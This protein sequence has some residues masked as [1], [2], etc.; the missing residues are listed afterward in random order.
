M[1]ILVAQREKKYG[2]FIAK[3]LKESG[4]CVD[5][6]DNFE[7]A[8]H[9]YNTLSHDFIIL[10]SFLSNELTADF[11]TALRKSSEDIGILILSPDD[12]TSIKVKAL[13]CGADDYVVKPIPFIELLARIKAILRRAKKLSSERLELSTLSVKDLTLNYLTREVK[14]GDKSIELTTRE[15]LLLE[16]FIRNKNIVLTRTVIKEK[17]WG[18]DFISGT[19]IVDVYMNYLRNKIDRGFEIKLFHTVRGAGYILKG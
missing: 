10:D 16:Y 15:Y 13:N 19:N 9:L 3:G 11:C 5:Y 6:T 12:N 8:Q 2:E 7:E 17:I 1:N 18:I 4:Y 14:R